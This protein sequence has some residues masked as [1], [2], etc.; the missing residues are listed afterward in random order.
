MVSPQRVIGV[1]LVV[2]ALVA[3]IVSSLYNCEAHNQNNSVATATTMMGGVTATT[4]GMG[5]STPATMGGAVGA[6]KAVTGHMP[7]YYSAKTAVLVAIPLGVLG[8]LLLVSRR[9]ETTRLLAV[10]GIVLGAVTMAVPVVVGTCGLVTMI[11]NE[12]M[13][14]TLLLVGGVAVVLSVILL[15]LGERRRESAG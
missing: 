1:A 12:V 13:K 11:C 15:V 5:S 10:M 9:R 2:L 3:A 4:R 6:S 7:C 14:P 8:L